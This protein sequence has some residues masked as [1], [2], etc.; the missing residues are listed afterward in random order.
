MKEFSKITLEDLVLMEKDRESSHIVK[1]GAREVIV[2]W[3]G[4]S[5]KMLWRAYYDDRHDVTA[6]A[7]TPWEALCDII[8]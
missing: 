2:E 3:E 8:D 6:L 7:P 4:R 5:P 1:H